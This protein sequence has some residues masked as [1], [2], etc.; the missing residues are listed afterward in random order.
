MPTRI[1][2]NLRWEAAV[3]EDIKRLNVQVVESSNEEQYT[4]EEIEEEI[5]K[6][7]NLISS[8]KS[9]DSFWQSHN[10]IQSILN[11]LHL[12]KSKEEISYGPHKVDSDVI[13]AHC[14]DLLENGG[15]IKEI[16][17]PSGT[18]DLLNNGNSNYEMFTQELLKYYTL[19]VRD[20]L[21][22]DKQYVPYFVKPKS[23]KKS[24]EQK[25]GSDTVE[26]K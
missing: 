8:T 26:N 10:Y 13:I 2:E 14:S 11:K 6:I 23:L 24:T 20:L 15:T 1:T 4:V 19:H 22:T 12:K 5:R 3:K 21:L 7:V 25:D 9:P 18:I 16:T 17:T